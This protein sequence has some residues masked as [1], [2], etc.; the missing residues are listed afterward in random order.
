MA[1]RSQTT[2]LILGISS[3][4]VHIL[5]NILF[6]VIVVMLITKYS[7]VAYDFAYEV[8]GEVALADAD[9]DVKEVTITINKGE[10][11]MSVASKL[12]LNRVINNKYAFYLRA[13]LFQS[14]IK[15]GRYK[16]NAAMSYEE[17][18]TVISDYDNNLDKDK[19]NQESKSSKDKSEKTKDGQEE[20]EN[21]DSKD[22]SAKTKSSKN[23]NSDEDSDD[24]N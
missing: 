22:T 18:L 19:D 10:S 12:E 13:K 16:V 11:T 24:I 23:Q 21:K 17:I 1:S 9:D 2:K 8:F 3:F 15:T 6:Y 5:L 7:G 14:N 20:S 4:V